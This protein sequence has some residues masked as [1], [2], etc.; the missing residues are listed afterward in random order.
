MKRGIVMIV[1][2]TIGLGLKHIANW[3]SADSGISGFLAR[4]IPRRPGRVGAKS[5][6]IP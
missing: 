2:G 6:T 4:A 3:Q 1:F 5:L